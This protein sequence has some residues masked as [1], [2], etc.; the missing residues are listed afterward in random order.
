MMKKIML[1]TFSIMATSMAASIMAAS[2]MAGTIVEIQDEDDLAT[3]MTDG[4]Y[5]RM[6]SSNS[7]YVIINLK[8]NS[9]KLVMPDD[10]EVMLIDT[11]SMP[12]G[13]SAPTVKTHISK[14]GAGPEI[15][16]YD[17]Q[18]YSF[19]ANN[20]SCGVIY[21]SADAA[22]AEGIKELLSAMSAI[23]EK[24]RA[25]MGGFTGMLSDCD[26]AEMNLTDQVKTVG[27]P[28]RIEKDGKTLSEIKSIKVGVDLP[29]DAFIIPAAYKTITMK[30]KMAEA[31]KAMKQYQPQMQDMMHQMQQSGQMTPEMMEQMRKAQEMMQ[32]Y[33]QR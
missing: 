9:I 31:Q 16:T 15:A 7:E 27:V 4:S 28:M 3:I 18:K 22:G 8:D 33:Q 25:M 21:G 29:Q 10:K 32:Q 11:N 24:Q 17:T 6:N 19:S 2:A 14:L 30:E 13:S 23:V 5:A 1:S 26:Q 20:K 12:S